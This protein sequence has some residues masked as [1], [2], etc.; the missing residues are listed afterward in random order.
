MQF[1]LKSIVKNVLPRFEIEVDY[2]H[3]DS[4][5]SN[6]SWTEIR[7]GDLKDL[8]K[9]ILLFDELKT[10]I[11]ENRRQSSPFP[12]KFLA[13]INNWEFNFQVDI[14]G[15]PVYI[16]IERDATAHEAML[17]FAEMTMMQVLFYDE[18]GEKFQVYWRD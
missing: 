6:S 3:G 9:Y 4:D 7:S 1:E 17:Y 14:D 5:H 13:D 2:E 11:R 18:K 12:D 10:A 8:E 15:E 16:E